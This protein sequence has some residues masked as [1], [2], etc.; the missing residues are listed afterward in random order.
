MRARCR[1]IKSALDQ[2]RRSTASAQRAAPNAATPMPGTGRALKIRGRGLRPLN[3]ATFIA[4]EAPK[5]TV[6]NRRPASP[7]DEILL[8]RA[9][10]AEGLPNGDAPSP[11][12]EGLAPGVALLGLDEPEVVDG[13]CRP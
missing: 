11:E 6:S 5:P 10:T 13:D 1:A 3:A 4:R 12:P 2:W 8:T 7:P 9:D